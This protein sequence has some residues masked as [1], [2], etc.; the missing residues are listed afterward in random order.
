MNDS[1]CESGMVAGLHEQTEA[2]DL[3]HH[4]LA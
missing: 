1:S 3:P 4:E 2:L